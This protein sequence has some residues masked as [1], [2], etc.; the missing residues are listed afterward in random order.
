MREGFDHDDIYMMVEDEFYSIAQSFTQ[1][2]H[3]AEYVRLKNIAKAKVRSNLSSESRPTDSITKMREELKRQKQAEAQAGK[4]K[5]ALSKLGG[6]AAR[7]RIKLS[8]EEDAESEAEEDDMWAGTTLKGLMTSP[9]KTKTSLM[10]LHGHKSNTR[11]AA[12]YS[13]PKAPDSKPGVAFNL[14]NDYSKTRD[15]G[16]QATA[17]EDDDDLDGPVRKPL[18]PHALKSIERDVS[19][20][21]ASKAT[22]ISTKS[23]NSYQPSQRLL[24]G[25]Y[26]YMHNAVSSSPSESETD[27]RPALSRLAV[28]RLSRPLKRRSG[29]KLGMEDAK[30]GAK[31][32]PNVN[33]IPIFLV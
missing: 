30:V 1:H 5:Q 11:A 27:D 7:K 23:K 33:E 21:L 2:L 22:A 16:S 3:H 25:A 15:E 32:Q 14:S 19:S 9:S 13:P 8:A 17:S 4:N 6:E 29:T 24:S 31:A 18:D 12:G 10:G 28:S 20:Q 26:D